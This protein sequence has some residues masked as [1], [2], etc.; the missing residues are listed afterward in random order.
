MELHVFDYQIL[1]CVRCAT[2]YVKAPAKM[3]SECTDTATISHNI[4]FLFSNT[5]AAFV[6]SD[7]FLGWLAC[8]QGY[9]KGFSDTMKKLGFALIITGLILIF[10]SISPTETKSLGKFQGGITKSD[11][12]VLAT[13]H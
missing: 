7:F 3:T 13:H 4:I 12:C 6:N 10:S 5:G 9:S 11:N 1:R 8:I 2:K